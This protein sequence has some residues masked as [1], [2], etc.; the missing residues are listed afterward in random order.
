MKSGIHPQYYDNA[1]VTC[2]CGNVVEA[3]GTVE[4][5][6][7]E[8]CSACHPFYTGKQKF[9]DTA[10]R[11]DRFKS[12]QAKA[13]EAKTKEATKPSRKKKT[14]EEKF[15]EAIAEQLKNEQDALAKKEEKKAAKKK[16]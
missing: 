11:V 1:T 5:I 16:K 9:V 12:M 10:G 8:V 6:K 4:S 13:D 14:M 15:N 7:I 2:S 3:G